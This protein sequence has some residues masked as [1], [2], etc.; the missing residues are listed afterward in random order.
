MG[1]L[2]THLPVLPGGRKLP[3]M[4]TSQLQMIRYS[5][6]RG[7]WGEGP[8]FFSVDEIQEAAAMATAS[9]ERVHEDSKDIENPTTGA[10][11]G[12]GKLTRVEAFLSSARSANDLGVKIAH[13]MTCLETL[14]S[15]DTAELSHKLS[16]RTALFLSNSPSD[17][18]D[19]YRAVKSAYGVRSKIV[20]GDTIA[21]SLGA[22]LP[23]ISEQCDTMLRKV[24][25]RLRG[26]KESLELLDGKQDTVD[27]H[28]LNLSFGDLPPQ[29]CSQS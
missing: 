20:H 21:P 17:R 16:E 27:S 9:L 11:R 6:A 3:S 14:F 8:T 5:T 2:E 7:G 15:T 24:L 28:F 1:F 4:I 26:D 12:V 18:M 22:R 10:Y 13:Y 19:T 25:N 23:E 29:D